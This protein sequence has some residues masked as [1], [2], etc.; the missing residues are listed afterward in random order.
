M[1][2]NKRDILF[3]KRD[4]I[5]YLFKNEIEDTTLRK[6]YAR[7]SKI[8]EFLQSEQIADVLEWDHEN[9]RGDYFLNQEMNLKTSAEKR[10]YQFN[11]I[12]A[13]FLMLLLKVD[14]NK[15]LNGIFRNMMTTQK[16]SSKEI[17]INDPDIWFKK[18][19]SQ[20]DSLRPF[21]VKNK[22]GKSWYTIKINI[23]SQIYKLLEIDTQKELQKDKDLDLRIET[24]NRILK[25]LPYEKRIV[26]LKDFETF[27]KKVIKILEDY[28]AAG[29]SE[30]DR[31]I[32]YYRA[33]ISKDE[34]ERTLGLS[35][36][37]E[38]SET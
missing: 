30:M 15:K 12:T 13:L 23:L 2:K 20:L 17:S 8:L 38:N 25:G 29:L 36:L 9:Y 19:G 10:D 1:G 5:D 11:T 7:L 16:K 26:L 4:I 3:S 37:I 24:V 33:G 18:V 32:F 22:D 28:E 27:E 21:W 31:L 35:E 34:L 6:Q 14:N